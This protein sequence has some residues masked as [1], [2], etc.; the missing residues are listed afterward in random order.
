MPNFTHLLN[1]ATPDC[2]WTQDLEYTDNYECDHG[3]VI[4]WYDV[5][6]HLQGAK[7]MHSEWLEENNNGN[8]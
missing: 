3:F 4:S 8:D 6:R 1:R 2:K 5:I 7:F